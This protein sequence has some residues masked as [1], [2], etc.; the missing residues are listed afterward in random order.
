MTNV[1]CYTVLQ[2]LTFCSCCEE[3]TFT[4]HYQPSDTSQILKFEFIYVR[5]ILTLQ[6]LFVIIVYGYAKIVTLDKKC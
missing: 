6:C 1:I 5:K 4:L 3:E 2:Y